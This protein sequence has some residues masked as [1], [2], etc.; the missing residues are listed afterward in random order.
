MNHDLMLTPLS[1]A[2]R[3]A[4]RL[5]TLDGYAIHH[6]PHGTRASAAQLRFL[7]TPV[8]IDTKLAVS[9]AS[10]S[11]LV[12]RR[13]RY[14]REIRLTPRER[15][16]VARTRTHGRRGAKSVP[17]AMRQEVNVFAPTGTPEAVVAAAIEGRPMR[18][19]VVWRCKW[20]RRGAP[21]WTVGRDR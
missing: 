14:A 11:E 19:E 18:Q 16:A 20:W 9:L 2:Y 10:S 7:V 17:M 4:E 5:A 12:L 21:I 15:R 13:C 1:A 6:A 8:S 3:P